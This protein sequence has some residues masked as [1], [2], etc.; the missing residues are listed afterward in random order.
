VK[1]VAKRDDDRSDDRGGERQSGKQDQHPQR[2]P[3]VGSGYPDRSSLV[4]NRRF[5]EV[6]HHARS[7]NSRHRECGCV[8]RSDSRLQANTVGSWALFT[9]NWL[10]RW[11]LRWITSIDPEWGIW[12]VPATDPIRDAGAAGLLPKSVFLARP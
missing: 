11:V 9:H 1:I 3:T 4:M 12:K 6:P 10:T 5:Y 2:P 7:I 8:S